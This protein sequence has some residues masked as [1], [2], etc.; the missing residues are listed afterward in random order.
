MT[1]SLRFRLM[2]WNTLMM[3]LLIVVTLVGVRTAVWY[4]LLHEI[5]QLLNEDLTEMRLV[6]EERDASSESRR[7]ESQSQLD[8][9]TSRHE[10]Q[11]PPKRGR[12]RGKS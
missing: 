12:R 1:G 7:R 5:E 8:R 10:S 3:L 9:K 2:L 4:T 11:G 6:V